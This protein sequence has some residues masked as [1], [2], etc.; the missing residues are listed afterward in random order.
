MSDSESPKP[1][2]LLTSYSNTPPSLFSLTKHAILGCLRARPV[3]A[4]LTPVL[5][6]YLPTA[7]INL[8]T[9][10]IYI[11]NPLLETSVGPLRPCT[12]YHSW[13]ERHVS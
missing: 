8:L 3:K 6:P 1:Q 4:E 2:Y 13:E 10:P 7:I 9:G 11:L 12:H 5:R